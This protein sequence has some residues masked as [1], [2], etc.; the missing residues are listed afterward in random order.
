MTAAALLIDAGNT[1]IK[2]ALHD[3][4]AAFPAEGAFEH[5]ATPH[6]WARLPRPRGAWLSNVAG[7]AAAEHLDAL[8]DAHWPALPRVVLR[9]SASAGGVRNGY[10]DPA[11]LGS[12]R[13]AGL[14]GARA[15]FP[16]EHLLLATL[17]TATTLE[18]LRADGYFLGGLIAPGWD[19]MMRSLGA[20]T[21]QLPTLNAEHAAQLLADAQ[22]EAAPLFAIDT[23]HALSAGSLHAQAGLIEHAWH[24]LNADLGEPVRLV[25]SGGAADMLAPVLRVPHTR[26]ASLVLA[27]LALLATQTDDA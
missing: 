4:G 23:P 16:G 21:A 27:G 12:D 15:A 2:W 3:G 20:H 9:A 24:A 13:W 17:G 18:A 8:L 26:H 25:V 22:H 7:A 5:G 1:R 6:E 10:R 11:Q 14:I 19:L